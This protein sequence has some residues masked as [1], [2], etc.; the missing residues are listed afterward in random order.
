MPN[1]PIIPEFITVH[2]GPPDSNARN[3]RVSF[4]EY[5]MNVASSE[6]F[7]TWPESALRANIYA[8]ISFALNRVY[9]EYYRIRGYDFD[10]TNSTA[11]DQYFVYGRDIFDNIRRIVGDIFTSYLRRRG[12]VEPLFAQ[13]CNGTTVTCDGLSQWGT[14]EL[15]N[16]GFTPYQILTN[17][18]GNDI[19]IVRNTPISGNVPSAPLIPL[20]AG[21]ANDDVRV[22]QIRLNRISTNYPAIP[23]IIAEDGIFTDDTERAVMAFQRVFGLTEDGIVG[24]STWYA[25]QYIYN[26]VKRLN[27]L[28]SEGIRFEEVSNELPDLLKE[29]DSGSDVAVF[30]Y[31][32][33]YIAGFYDTI[34]PIAIDGIFG[35]STRN[36]V[37][38]AQKTF[39][40]V[41]DGIVGENTWNAVYKAYRGIVDTIPVEYTEGTVIPFPGVTLTLGSESDDVSVLQSY[42]NYIAQTYTEIPSIPITG[43]YGTRTREAVIAFQ[44]RFGLP[45]TGRVNAL[46]WSAIASIYSD[47]Y[48]GRRISD[49]QFPGFEIGG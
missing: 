36:S 46:T 32:L 1:Q 14:V 7:P 3:V 24:N 44:R 45:A 18:Y 26:S 33:S 17:Y 43:Y 31:F 8:Q 16:N 28:N 23:K 22:I 2:L 25:I 12:S 11:I 21:I 5:I 37:I 19:E 39:G 9:T 48:N 6:I 4:P 29:G 47:L 15:A 41:Q 34:L 38:S 27:E 49:G 10:I 20:R 13:Y 30:Q 42:L 40:L 35:E